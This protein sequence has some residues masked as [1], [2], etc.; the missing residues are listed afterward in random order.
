MLLGDPE[1]RAAGDA[2]SDSKS[3]SRHH[4]SNDSRCRHR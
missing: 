2:V 1:A 3:L 4:D